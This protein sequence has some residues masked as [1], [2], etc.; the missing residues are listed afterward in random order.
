VSQYV[1]EGAS[2]ADVVRKVDAR[3]RLALWLSRFLPDIF[4]LLYLEAKL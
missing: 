3:R 1:V 2:V 4:F